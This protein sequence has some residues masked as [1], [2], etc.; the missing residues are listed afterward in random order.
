MVRQIIDQPQPLTL[1][2]SNAECLAYTHET[3]K[4]NSIKIAY[5][6]HY[7]LMSTQSWELPEKRS[8]LHVTNIV[9]WYKT[10]R[11]LQ[12]QEMTEIAIDAWQNCGTRAANRE[13]QNGAE[14]WWPKTTFYL[15]SFLHAV[16]P[17]LISSPLAANLK[18]CKNCR[19]CS[20]CGTEEA[21]PFMLL[22]SPSST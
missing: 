1:Y 16:R 11:R 14:Y 17:R 22:S 7:H 13:K 19:R 20:V 15:A 2:S 12:L 9:H 5:Q 8:L 4:H 18:Q 21:E 10:D 3:D 6:S